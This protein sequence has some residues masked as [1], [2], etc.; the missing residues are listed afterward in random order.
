MSKALGRPSITPWCQAPE[1]C[2]TKPLVRSLVLLA[3]NRSV[4]HNTALLNVGGLRTCCFD[5]IAMERALTHWRELGAL[6]AFRRLTHGVMR[7]D[8]FRLLAMHHMHA[9]YFDAK[10]GFQPGKAVEC[11]EALAKGPYLTLNKAGL[12]TNWHMHGVGHTETND[13]MFRHIAGGIIADVLSCADV[14]RGKTFAERVWALTG[15]VACR[16]HLASYRGTP[17]LVNAEMDCLVYD[18]RGAGKSWFDT[19]S[20]HKRPRAARLYHKEACP[21]PAPSSKGAR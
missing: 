17:R 12:L 13:T 10:S 2:W 9:Y 20:Y 16:R 14:A 18:V 7:V 8:L 3:T 21:G 15:P 19:G 11:L 5:D 1:A 4:P 6:A